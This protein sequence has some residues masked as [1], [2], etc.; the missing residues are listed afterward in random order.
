MSLGSIGV[1]TSNRIAQS[2]VLSTV[3]MRRIPQPLNAGSRV[4]WGWRGSE[5]AGK[6]KPIS[7][8]ADD[9]SIPH[10]RP[11][12]SEPEEQ[13]PAPGRALRTLL[14]TT[15]P[16]NA[17]D[18][19]GSIHPS[20]PGGPISRSLAGHDDLV[21]LRLR[22]SRVNEASAGA[23]PGAVSDPGGKVL[24]VQTGSRILDAPVVKGRPRTPR[25]GRWGWASCFRAE[26]VDLRWWTRLRRRNVA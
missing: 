26:V 16:D 14:V 10:P 7:H 24:N 2:G 20:P 18:S 13:T 1:S 21:R 12:G 5:R 22:V 17:Q 4:V 25:H 9:I 6:L 8:V 3:A 11:A 15:H 19:A 23:G